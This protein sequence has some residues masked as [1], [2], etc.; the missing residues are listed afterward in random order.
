MATTT[1]AIMIFH[2]SFTANCS[3]FNL[4]PALDVNIRPGVQYTFYTRDSNPGL[5]TPLQYD[6][7]LLRPGINMTS[8]TPKALATW[9]A[10]LHAHPEWE[11]RFATSD[12]GDLEI[13][14]PAPAGS[15]AHHLLILTYGC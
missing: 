12:A 1:T 15:A 7:R 5:D 2:L 11:D 3:L 9:Q 8:P 4:S 13:E 10:L 6:R 14:I